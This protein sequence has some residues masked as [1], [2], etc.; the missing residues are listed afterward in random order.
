[1]TPDVDVA[2]VGLGPVGG[3]L[4]NLLA[5][6]GLSVWVFDREP[7]VMQIPRGV[8]MDAEMMRIFQTVGLAEPL[9]PQLKVFRGAQYLDVDGNVV[10]TRPGVT[11][12]G[13]QGWPARYNLHQPDLE[14]VLRDGLQRFPQAKVFTSHEVLSATNAGDHAVLEVQDL[15]G[16]RA[17]SVSASFV[18]GCDGGRSLIRKM[19][20]VELDDF[21]LNQPW[22]VYD[23]QVTP[24]ADVPEINTHY[25]DPVAPAIYIHV[26]RDIR[27]FEF[28]ARPDE[29]LTAA[30]EPDVA[31]SR[32]RRWLTPDNAALLR[33]AVYTHRALVARNWRDGRLLVAGD[34]AHQTP[35]FLGQGLCAGMRDA[36]ALA[37]RLG[38][39]LQRGSDL[40]ILD[41][42]TGERAE[43]A[44]VLIQ[45]ATKLGETLTAPDRKRLEE[46]NTA[47]GREGRGSAPRL[48]AG[49]WV[50]D[51]IGGLLAPQ[52]RLEDGRL[53]DDVVGYRFA[54]LARPQVCAAVGDEGRQA[55]ER[56]G[57]VLVEASGEALAW[58]DELGAEAALIR[59]DRYGYG[60]FSNAAG[61]VAAVDTVIASLDSRVDAA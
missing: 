9:E 17:F 49:L 31:W 14:V 5:M 22:I 47:V 61:L 46:L 26:V 23:F 58:L 59:P 24:D 33:A 4:A 25:A 60:A 21:G 45:T 35:P 12:P 48:G 10:A 57:V 34:A 36:S 42:Y 2:I 54:A 32:V 39:I 38:A 50:E 55:W 44:R 52:P 30:T 37:W 11:G 53:L 43:H 51:A 15:A 16:D 40:S 8:G 27:R 41:T 13:P 1:M 6:Q 20:N 28:R 3:T 7:E 29:D 19:A 56:H 18:V